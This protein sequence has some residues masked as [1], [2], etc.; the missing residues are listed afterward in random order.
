MQRITSDLAFTVRQDRLS[1]K[2]IIICK[3]RRIYQEW[4]RIYNHTFTWR[5]ACN[6]EDKKDI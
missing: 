5:Y 6:E 1:E 2:V 4:C 3:K